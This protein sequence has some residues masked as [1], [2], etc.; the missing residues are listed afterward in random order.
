[1]IARIQPFTSANHMERT[2][3]KR[4]VL[5]KHRNPVCTNWHYD[6]TVMS[7]KMRTAEGTAQ[8]QKA[9]R[10]STMAESSALR[11]QNLPSTKVILC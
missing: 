4:T 6:V 3:R 5:G 2:R 1:M 11:L 8:A 9:L 7:E 10:T